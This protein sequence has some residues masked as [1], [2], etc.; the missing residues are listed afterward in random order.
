[1]DTPRVRCYGSLPYRAAVV[2]GGPGAPGSV[3]PVAR[4]LAACGIGTIEPLLTATTLQGQID[5]LADAIRPHSPLTL[6]GHSWGAWLAY[7]TAARYPDLVHELILVSAGPFEAHYAADILPTRLNHLDEA[8]RVKMQSYLAKWQAGTINQD[9]FYAF[10]ALCDRADTY[11]P[12]PD[13]DHSGML[14]CEGQDF[15]GVWDEA[16]AMRRSGELLSLASK[17]QCPV[18]A[19]HGDYDPHP[20]RGVQES[21]SKAFADFHFILLAKC[22][23]TPWEEAYT[24]EAFYQALIDALRLY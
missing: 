1:M 4:Y 12:A 10:G 2:H 24:R 17:I 21:L 22:G 18:T 8:D 6:I 20:Y 15:L 3:A 23:H 16:D 9:E 5:E 13:I 7:L 19:I 11:K 14:P